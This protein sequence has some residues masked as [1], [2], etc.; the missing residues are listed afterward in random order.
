TPVQSFN[1]KIKEGSIKTI[2]KAVS[3]QV[4][5]GGK[6]L[7]PKNGIANQ[8]RY[9]IYIGASL[10]INRTYL[11]KQRRLMQLFVHVYC[12]SVTVITIYF[13]L[14]HDVGKGS[15]KFLRDIGWIEYLLL[16]LIAMITKKSCL[17]NLFEDLCGFDVALNIK[18]DLHVTLPAGRE[19]WWIMFSFCYTMFEY[20]LLFAY[21]FNER[22]LSE[23]IATTLS[24]VT[25]MT[26]DIEQLLFGSILRTIFMRVCILKAH[27]AKVLSVDGK[28]PKRKLDKV[29]VLSNKAQL[30]INSLHRNYELLHKCAEQLVFTFCFQMMVMLLCSGL[31]TIMLM[32]GLFKALLNKNINLQMQNTIIVY[33]STRCLKYTFQVVICCYYSSVTTSQVSQIRTML[34]ECKMLFFS[35]KLERRR[36]KAFFQLTRESEFAYALWGVIRLNMS[37]PL[38]YLSLCTTY[39]VIII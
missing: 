15:Y 33:S 22:K 4:A 10:G 29:E 12:F 6:K 19:W 20:I 9:I 30:D 38:S 35:D 39:L 26:H 1:M 2:S 36:I 7:E 13:L 3:I 14:S 16:V 31:S 27:V 32:K 34:H 24:Y 37:L 17:R 5:P 18:D 25:L 21:V 23:I 8:L 28:E 11:L